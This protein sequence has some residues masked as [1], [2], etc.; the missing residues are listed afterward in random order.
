[1]D[2]NLIANRTPEMDVLEVKV[3]AFVQDYMNR[4]V[5]KKLGNEK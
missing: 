3:K 4:I 1:M 2:H 5:D